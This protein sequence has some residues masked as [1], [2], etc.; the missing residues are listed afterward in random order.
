[1]N[2]Q[3]A[4]YNL[5]EIVMSKSVS[6]CKL[7]P[8]KRQAYYD[9]STALMTET[10]CFCLAGPRRCG[11]TIVL[12]Q[13]EETK[14]NVVY[15]NFK[16]E[17]PEIAEVVFDNIISDI[18]TGTSR[19]Y[20]LDEVT[21][22]EGY[23][24]FISKFDFNLRNVKIVFTG[25]QGRAIERACSTAFGGMQVVIRMGFYDFR[26]YLIK[27]GKLQQGEFVSMEKLNLI[28]T[29]EDYKDYLRETYS[30]Y[31][32]IS[33]NA[34]YLQGC[35]DE[36]LISESKAYFVGESVTKQFEITEA[37]SVLYAV[38]VSLHNRVS[39]NGLI[40]MEGLEI[41]NARVIRKEDVK[42]FLKSRSLHVGKML[43]EKFKA[44][45]RFLLD[46]DFITITAFRSSGYSQSKS[47]LIDYLYNEL[48][49]TPTEFLRRYCVNIK[50]PLFYI[51][52][53]RDLGKVCGIEINE[54]WLTTGLVLGSILECDLKGRIS[55]LRHTNILEEYKVIT[56][57][58]EDIAEV[59][60]VDSM[61]AIEITV[62]NKKMNKVHLRSRDLQGLTKYLLTKDKYVQLEDIQC[63]PYYVFMAGLTQI[64]F[65]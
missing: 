1:M 6:Y 7:Y 37:V 31:G 3:K 26:E 23:D 13:I 24:S 55:V 59:D 18:E 30:F 39:F 56:Y 40:Q 38:L 46:C 14:E 53:V 25:S 61:V 58:N 44:I 36:S 63:I 17:K 54:Q 32:T 42:V 5:E 33:D 47:E 43:P 51:N 60:Y 57:D 28:V 11:K 16:S 48:Y 19:I 8:F 29:D 20:L 4:L 35:L 15:Y 21:Y 2:I 10:Q 22:I 49:L 45:I 64:K 65:E 12:H 34:M 9:L 62:S 50:Y 52:L 27:C 41:P